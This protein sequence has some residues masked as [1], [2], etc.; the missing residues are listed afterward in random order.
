MV[1]SEWYVVDRGTDVG[2]LSTASDFSSGEDQGALYSNVAVE[3]GVGA[4]VDIGVDTRVV[5]TAASVDGSIDGSTLVAEVEGVAG[6]GR[7]TGVESGGLGRAV[8]LLSHGHRDAVSIANTVAGASLGNSIDVDGFV[9]DNWRVFANRK[10]SHSGLEHWRKVAVISFGAAASGKR[11]ISSRKSLA[12]VVSSHSEGKLT[13][14]SDGS[15]PVAGTVLVVDDGGQAGAPSVARSHSSNKIVV[16]GNVDSGVA[17]VVT[18]SV[19]AVRVEAGVIVAAASGHSGSVDLS[20][21]IGDT[22]LLAEGDRVA[23][24]E[25]RVV[26][27]SKGIGHEGGHGT[28]SVTHGVASRRDGIS[29]E[30]ESSI[31]KNRV[32]GGRDGSDV[33]HDD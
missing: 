4:T 5:V 9:A 30:V 21:T 13:A 15:A 8:D 18:R 11:R 32:V 7:I 28:F 33:G 16:V 26:L 6:V 29:I 22:H 10:W 23:G 14:S 27:L 25:S 31:A 12:V 19:L 2:A 17:G 20:T 24:V 1:G 3:G